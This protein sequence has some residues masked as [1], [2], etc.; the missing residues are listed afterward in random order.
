MT[1]QL[2]FTSCA[3]L[4]VYASMQKTNFDKVREKT[5]RIEMKLNLP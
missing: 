5:D 4:A 3:R 2:F 1:Y